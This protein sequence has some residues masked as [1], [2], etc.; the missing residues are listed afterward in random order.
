M[1]DESRVIGAARSDLDDD[2]YRKEIKGALE[3]FIEK[4]ERPSNVV[5]EFLAQSSFYKF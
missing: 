1:P 2:A 4:D 5:K 3:E